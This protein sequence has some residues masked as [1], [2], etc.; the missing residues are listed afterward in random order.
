FEFVGDPGDGFDPILF[1]I[2]TPPVKGAFGSEFHT[3]GR[4]W[5]ESRTH[6]V[7]VY[8]VDTT[9]YLLSPTRYPLIPW[10]LQQDGGEE[11]VLLPACTESVGRLFWVPKGTDSVAASL[12]VTDVTRQAESHGVEIPVV[13]RDDFRDDRVSLLAVP[14]DRRYRLTLRIYALLETEQLINI[15][16][17][18]FLRH[19][20]YLQPGPSIF[21]PAY[22][23]FTDFPLPEELPVEQDTIR[24]V[25]D[26]SRGESEPVVPI[27]A[28]ITVTNN[29]TQHITTV[30]P[31]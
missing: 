8:G 14:I 10:P 3:R 22:A 31:N 19:Q 29:E 27:W 16:V 2:L 7:N 17:N 23:Q 25:V 1:P 4:M 13:H 28:F 30:T 15:S 11:L 9:C 21:E 5:N 6:G 18:G 26:A 12:R 20:L 24:V